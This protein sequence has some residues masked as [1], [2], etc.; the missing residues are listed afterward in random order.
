MSAA[1]SAGYPNVLL[2][3]PPH[4]GKK[5]LVMQALREMYGGE[6]TLPA[7]YVKIIDCCSSSN[8]KTVRGEVKFFAKM[9]VQCPGGCRKSVVLLNSDFLTTEAQ[10]ALRR[11]IEVHNHSTR[12]FM[13]VN[14]IDLV[15]RPIVSRFSTRF[16]RAATR[17]DTN[18]TKKDAR[19]LYSVVQRVR[20]TTDTARVLRDSD[21]IYKRGIP[22]AMLLPYITDLKERSEMEALYHLCRGGVREDRLIISLLL[23]KQVVRSP[24]PIENV[25]V[26]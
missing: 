11:C 23:L 21:K 25:F 14:N 9:R 12:F 26:I 6:F 3:G 13:T 24:L 8:I 2:H 20:Q 15:M 17:V 4:G 7:D 5:A 10:S 1:R 16:V 18:V 19:W 22:P